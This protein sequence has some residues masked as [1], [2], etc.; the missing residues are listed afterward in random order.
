MP[1]CGPVGTTVPFV[2]S[3]SGSAGDGGPGQRIPLAWR[4]RVRPTRAKRRPWAVKPEPKPREGTLHERVTNAHSA[5]TVR[6]TCSKKG[7]RRLEFF[8]AKRAARRDQKARWPAGNV[9]AAFCAEIACR[10]ANRRAFHSPECYFGA[11]STAARTPSGRACRCRAGRGSARHS[12]GRSRRRTH[13]GCRS[14]RI[15]CRHPRARR[16]A[17]AAACTL[18]ATS[19]A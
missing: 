17:C 6:S 11:R 12:P 19:D 3:S 8:S 10:V 14:R 9:L 7:G 5:A 15:R 2:S 1:V 4:A 13:W 16:R 18:A